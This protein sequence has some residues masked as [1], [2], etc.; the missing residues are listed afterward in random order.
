ML[1]FVKLGKTQVNWLNQGIEAKFNN[2]WL[3]MDT[4]LNLIRF[5][6][7]WMN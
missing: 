4:Q 5:S 2:I 3:N 6:K 7:T 1:N